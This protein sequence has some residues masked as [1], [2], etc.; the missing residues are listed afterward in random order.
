MPILIRIAFASLLIV[1]LQAMA[2]SSKADPDYYQL[3][4]LQQNPA[5]LN[6]R[7][8]ISD[9]LIQL[10]GYVF[11]DDSDEL[12]HSLKKANDEGQALQGR[13]RG[14]LVIPGDE[15][16]LVQQL[17]D[18]S[19][20]TN[21]FAAGGHFPLSTGSPAWH[22]IGG[23][24]FR[25]SARFNYD[26]NDAD[27]LRFATVLGLFSFGD[28]QSAM[29]VSALWSNYLAVNYRFK[30]DGVENTQFGI[31]PKIQNISLIGRSIVIS[32]YEEEKLFDAGRDVD[33]NL[34]LN[35]DLGISHQ[36]GGWVL[37]LAVQDLY[38]QAMQSTIGTVYQQ[39]SQISVSSDYRT[40][41]AAFRLDADVTPQ[42]GFGEIPAQRAYELASAIP[43]SQRIELLLG[44]RWLDNPYSDDAPSI[45]LHYSLDKLLH[46]NAQ[47]S[48]AGGNELGGS[49]A[50]QI[51]L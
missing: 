40:S 19:D 39:R 16:E 8:D 10:D 20:D 6:I 42:T 5:A 37:G 49:I 15:A 47:F 14:I 29:E 28:L 34:Q 4:S 46:I 22:I 25:G 33:H 38:Q 21:S 23:S 9:T 27:R 48:Y 45:G 24:A 32:E 51:P 3:A 43:L 44:Y 18:M 41:W 12:I 11:V 36:F 1:S 50:L 2:A 30:I 31:S 35:A 13:S 26:E 17:E 7:D